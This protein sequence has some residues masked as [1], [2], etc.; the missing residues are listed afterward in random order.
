MYFLNFSIRI[1][2]CKGKGLI[3]FQ[4]LYFVLFSYHFIILHYIALSTGINSKVQ[5]FRILMSGIS[6]LRLATNLHYIWILFS[7]TH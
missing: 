2:F 3:Y 5:N 4:N 6:R 7:F 1:C